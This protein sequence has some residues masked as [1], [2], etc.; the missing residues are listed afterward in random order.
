MYSL[1]LNDHATQTNYNKMIQIISKNIDK[2]MTSLLDTLE[3]IDS[4]NEATV[5]CLQDV[6]NISDTELKNLIKQTTK[7]KIEIRHSLQDE[8]KSRKFLC[9]TILVGDNVQITSST[10]SQNDEAIYINIDVK[11]NHRPYNITNVYIRPRSSYQA[12]EDSLTKIKSTITGRSTT[13]KD[14]SIIVGDINGASIEWSPI[15][16]HTGDPYT[17][18]SN[19]KKSRGA[20]FEFLMRQMKL[21]NLL[22]ANTTPTY[23]NQTTKQTS[24]IDVAYAG[25]KL[26]KK[27]HDIRVEQAQES[28]HS[29]IQLNIRQ[30]NNNH[31]INNVKRI[32]YERINEKCFEPLYAKIDSNW[33]NN[34]YGL[35]KTRLTTIMNIMT[36]HLYEELLKIQAEITTIKKKRTSSNQLKLLIKQ[37]QLRAKL[38]ASCRKYKRIRSTAQLMRTKATRKLRKRLGQITEQIIKTNNK[39]LW[40]RVAQSENITALKGKSTVATN[41]TINNAATLNKIAEEKFP[42]LERLDASLRIKIET[43]GN[44]AKVSDEEIDQAIKEV[45]KKKHAGADK[46]NIQMLIASIKFTKPIVKAICKQSFQTSAIPKICQ[47]TRGVIIPKKQPGKF[48]IVHVGS[49]LMSIIESIATNRLNH[50]LENKKQ[51]DPYQY[52]FVAERSRHDL[53]ARLVEVCAKHKQEHGASARTTIVNL[54]IKGAFDNVCQRTLIG[55]IIKN[56]EIND[57][58]LDIRKW[59]ISYILNREIKLEYGHITAEARS[60]CTG[61][62]QGSALGPALWNFYINQLD[63]EIY[64][65]GT[66]ELLKYADDI[67][68]V[69]N[70]ND[71]AYLQQALDKVNN[72]LADL[73]LEVETSKCT[74]MGIDFMG[75]RKVKETITCRINDEEIPKTEKTKH[76]GISIDTTLRLADDPS[77]TAKIL[78]NTAKI[79]KLNNLG[80]IRNAQEVRILIDSLIASVTTHNNLIL[81]AYDKRAQT[82][83]ESQIA[84][85]IKH[86]FGWP[87][88]SSTKLARLLAHTRSPKITALKEV[89]LKQASQHAESYEAIRKVA[90]NLP[91]INTT[92]KDLKAQTTK[93]IYQSPKYLIKTK[94]VE[95]KEEALHGKWLIINRSNNKLTTILSGANQIITNELTVTHTNGRNQYIQT[96][97]LLREVAKR[98]EYKDVGIISAKGKHAAIEAICNF[99]NRDTRVLEVRQL[100]TEAGQ[101]I[102]ICSSKQLFEEI[103]EKTRFAKEMIRITS[104]TN[105]PVLTKWPNISD[106]IYKSKVNKQFELIES[107]YVQEALLTS[108]CK[109]LAPS[110]SSWTKI[111]IGRM[112]TATALTLGGLCSNNNQRITKA[113]E[114]FTCEL[115]GERGSHETMHRAFECR[116]RNDERRR[117]IITSI[118][119]ANGQ[120]Q[121]GASINGQHIQKTIE[122]D[123]YHQALLR[124]LSKFAFE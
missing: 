54:D 49:A 7:Q 43:L 108:T 79:Y 30:S 65:A 97:A 75:R 18:Y 78:L 70:G 23:I 76:L 119:R 105:Q 72:K 44:N 114:N 112:R 46:L 42:T 118:A 2:R 106:Y 63:D 40:E 82:K 12:Q 61:V 1:A 51:I 45:R 53:M 32:E 16:E 34:W 95:T 116:H 13:N 5:L 36:N 52:G 122:H 94:Q 85:A 93:E 31:K 26:T 69:Y 66:L 17:N 124:I 68:I 121:I 87:A 21:N 77:I 74:T 47:T 35:D 104:N 83:T 37:S 8:Q 73:K 60:V 113:R 111:H 3:R 120:Q 9:T 20:R 90:C 15:E 19:L 99:A 58:Q 67:M 109:H 11:I 96:L 62:P 102:S 89:S 88:N 59:L 48:R 98:K 107:N 71:G 84:R 24:Y 81:L 22:C 4:I 28:G 39:T 117:E 115:C 91:L 25:N 6:M 92:V 38:D 55:K 33:I 123:L 56:L 57:K 86:A 27:A 29:T 10:N 80:L 64:N 103:K 110:A 100:M 50:A 14:W 101:Y 41:Q